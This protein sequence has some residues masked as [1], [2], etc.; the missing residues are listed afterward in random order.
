MPH[1]RRLTLNES[2]PRPKLPDHPGRPTFPSPFRSGPHLDLDR[3]PGLPAVCRVGSNGEDQDE[4][5][6][7]GG[8]Y[9]TAQ[10]T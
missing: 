8:A 9:Y 7:C 6:G 10:I 1:R 3:K 2:T 4:I 5:L